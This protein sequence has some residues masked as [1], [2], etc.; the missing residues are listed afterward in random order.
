MHALFPLFF[1]ALVSSL[2][3]QPG[4]ILYFRDGEGNFEFA[5]SDVLA[6]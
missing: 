6:K 1:C 2:I 3:M 4:S 5:N